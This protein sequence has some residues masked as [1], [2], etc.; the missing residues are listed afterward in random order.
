MNEIFKGLSVGDKITTEAIN[1]NF[2]AEFSGKIKMTRGSFS[3]VRTYW[4]RAYRKKFEGYVSLEEVDGEELECMIGDV[5]I[6]NINKLKETLV[7]SGLNTLASNMGFSYEE[8]CETVTA[9]IPKHTMFSVIFGTDAKLWELV[10]KEERFKIELK[11][12]IDNYDDDTLV[13]N[14]FKRQFGIEVVDGVGNI[15]PN[16]VPTKEQLIEKLETL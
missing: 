4:V 8:F 2:S 1:E 5:P 12:A 9:N 7:N 14:N 13:S 11:F 15:I 10:P 3:Q 6:D 16:G